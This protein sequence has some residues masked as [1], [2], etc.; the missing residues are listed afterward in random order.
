MI[1]T[2][3]GKLLKRGE[4]SIQIDVN[5]VGYEVFVPM[6]VLNELKNAAE[7]QDVALVTYHYFATDP[8]RSI[9]V[10]V[11]FMNEIE[12]EFFEK[13][14]TVSGV[15][16]KAAI[17]AMNKPLSEIARAIDAGDEAFLRSLPG[18]G[19]QRAKEIIAKLQN[20]V[21]KFGLMKD[22]FKTSDVPIRQDIE[23][24]ALQVL[25]KLQ[26]KKHEAQEMLSRAL[27]RK[28]DIA[29]GE[30]LLNEVYRQRSGRA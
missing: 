14:I 26:Y 16:P 3:K 2:I 6:T 8:S 22:S 19:G 4:L 13:F 10:L 27:E 29:S 23:N 18:I 7:G 15:G 30:E 11:G 5:G 9:P 17:K 24:E 12:K 25:L 21:G 1:S 28:P 20:K